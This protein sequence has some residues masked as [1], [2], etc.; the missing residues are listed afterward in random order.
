MSPPPLIIRIDD[1]LIHGQVLVGWCSK[2]PIKKFIIGD[3]EI[4]NNDWEKNLILSATSSDYRTEILS[5]KDTCRYI[6]E[7]LT[8]S[9]S[10]MILVDSPKQIKRMNK[11]G[12]PIKRI[13]VGGIHYREGR[14]QY[15]RFLFLNNEEVEIFRQLMKDGF[16]FECQDLPTN[17]KLDLRKVLESHQ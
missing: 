8:S 12:L 1:R 13:N 10:T 7:S 15:L 14:I 5:I 11:I 4:A 3:D 2:F 17:K 6:N 9:T 16:I